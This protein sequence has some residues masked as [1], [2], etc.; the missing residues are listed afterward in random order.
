MN[1]TITWEYAQNLNENEKRWGEAKKNLHVVINIF[2]KNTLL[3]LVSPN[4]YYEAI[5]MNCAL[6]E[7][8]RGEYLYANIVKLTNT[9]RE[10]PAFNETYEKYFGK[11]N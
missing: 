10:I 3:Q 11:A 9:V 6:V 8:D 1:T 7:N 5:S 2:A 4:T